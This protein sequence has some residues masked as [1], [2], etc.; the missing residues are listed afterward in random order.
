MALSGPCVGSGGGEGGGYEGLGCTTSYLASG[1]SF[2][3][4]FPALPA[5]TIPRSGS[6]RGHE[7]VRNDQDRSEICIVSLSS[8]PDCP[9]Y[10]N[11]REHIKFVSLFH[12]PRV[13]YALLENQM[14]ILHINIAF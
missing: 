10:M 12:N 9:S 7:R 1:P 6:F 2:S 13:L 5:R 14:D 8:D 3:P 11:V 4:E